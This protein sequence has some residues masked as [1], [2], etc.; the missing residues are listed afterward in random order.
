[1]K[2]LPAFAVAALALLSMP[3]AA[4]TDDFSTGGALSLPFLSKQA[5]GSAF[6]DVQAEFGLSESLFI[7]GELGAMHS[8]DD[9]APMR[10]GLSPVIGLKFDVVEW[11]PYAASGPTCLL[12]V[13]P[14]PA[15]GF[16][17]QLILGL[18]YRLTRSL[19]LGAQ[20]HFSATVDDD[21]ALLHRAGLRAMYHWG[22]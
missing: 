3:A 7:G 19:S 1:M 2:R 20:Y 6:W 11:V 13:E 22:W 12:G 17:A 16:G 8:L 5:S 15:V 10:F 4:A 9:G 21:A 18:D 14:E